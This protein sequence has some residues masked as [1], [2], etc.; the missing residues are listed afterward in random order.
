MNRNERRLATKKAI[1]Q[2]AAS[3][4]AD[5]RNN[6]EKLPPGEPAMAVIDGWQLGFSVHPKLGNHLS[7]SKVS[8][9]AS[10]NTLRAAKPALGMPDDAKDCSFHVSEHGVMH[11]HWGKTIDSGSVGPP[12][13]QVE[14]HGNMEEV[15]QEWAV[16]VLAIA[17]EAA[18]MADKLGVSTAGA[19]FSL[20][21][22]AGAKVCI[23]MRRPGEAATLPHELH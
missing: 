6:A 5:L 7:A 15:G 16:I 9:T 4:F 1:A 18:K 13:Y 21:T 2:G 17:S 12:G 3:N 22:P 11:W 14:I 19:H 10:E 8:P 23:H 20:T